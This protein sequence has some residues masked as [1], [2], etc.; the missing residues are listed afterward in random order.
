[1][2]KPLVN[3]LGGMDFAALAVSLQAAG[4]IHHLPPQVVAKTSSGR[5]PRL[6]VQLIQSAAQAS[7]GLL[8][9]CRIPGASPKLYLQFAPGGR[10][11]VAPQ[12]YHIRATD[13]FIFRL[14]AFTNWSKAENTVSSTSRSS[15]G[16]WFTTRA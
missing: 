15:S 1:M 11:A 16:S 8:A 2:F 10:V 14:V 13:R 3:R 7:V 5:S 12:S 9:A 4:S 6:P